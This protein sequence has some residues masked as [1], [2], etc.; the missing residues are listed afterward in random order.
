M[1]GRYVAVCMTELEIVEA[2]GRGPKQPGKKLRG[3]YVEEENK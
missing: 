2:Q 3:R 1:G